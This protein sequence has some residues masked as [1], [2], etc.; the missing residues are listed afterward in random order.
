[1]Y[2]ERI[3]GI[4]DYECPAKEGKG[5]VECGNC[6]DSTE[7]KQGDLYFFF[8]TMSG[9]TSLRP[10]FEG[11]NEFRDDAPE[12]IDFLFR[13][14]GYQYE[15]LTSDFEYRVRASIDNDKPVIAR[16][17]NDHKNPFRVLI[18]YENQ[19]LFFAESES[20]GIKNNNNSPLTCDDISEVIVINEKVK[21]QFAL[22]DGLKRIQTVMSNNRES[23][24]W[25]N[26]IK[27]FMYWDEKLQ[28]AD[29]SELK[30]RFMRMENI[31][32]CNFN[33]HNFAEV[34]RHRRLEP[35]KDE[36]LDEIC[37][38]IDSS[39]SN[40]HTQNW[41]ICGLYVCREWTKREYNEVEW[42]YCTCAVQCLEKLK[43]Y[44]QEVLNAINKA[45]DILS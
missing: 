4:N 30:Y 33:S 19:D 40:F 26:Y 18:G 23:K 7:N 16:M 12:N 35:L 36:R 28:D 34:F 32:R 44:D 25:D 38:Q 41:Q 29:V 21:P 27:K 10:N 15:M 31:A 42:G 37:R 11:T 45:I 9:R 39:Y 14:I 6:N 1:M 22:I 43:E 8:D 17:K 5:C 3:T 13:F 20:D 24:V 2:L